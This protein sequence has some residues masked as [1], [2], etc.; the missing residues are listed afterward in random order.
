MAKPI[1]V[2][3][4]GDS[5][6]LKKTLKKTT[7]SLEGFGKSVAKVGATAGVAFAA[8]AGAIATK[9]LT[10]F[11]AYERGLREVLTLTGDAS[12][13]TFT[14]M[15]DEVK[16][17]ARET[18]V[19]PDKV[20][21]ALY[22]SI[23]AG[24][25][26]DNVFEFLRVANQAAKGGIADLEVAVDALTSVTAAYASTGMTAVEASDLLFSAVKSGKTDFSQLSSEIYKVAPIAS[27]VGIEFKSV[28]A[29]LADLTL[30][31]TPTALA[32]S[33]L[34]ALF[35]ELA[36]SGSKADTAFRE[37]AGQGMM[38]FLAGRLLPGRT[39]A[40]ERRRRRR[41]RQRS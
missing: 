29:A 3:I 12:A 34:K 27:A 18:G 36:S 32:A 9:G 30:Q 20:L 37:F 35:A 11:A 19:L 15:S 26:Q 16:A 6:Q 17:F 5:S 31:G 10:A 8:T 7:K 4:I 38:D 25:P 40:D 13:E 41:R 23:S 24:V 21:P 1:R 22:Q 33:Q 28:T 39:D 14:K 2:A